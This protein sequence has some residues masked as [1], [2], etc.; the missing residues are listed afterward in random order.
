[1]IELD[2]SF[3]RIAGLRHLD[4]FPETKDVPAAVVM[5]FVKVKEEYHLLF[6][7]RSENLRN[8]QRTDKFS[9]WT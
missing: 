1:M 7:K 2:K 5:L 3:P 6:T 8:T 4:L 9:W